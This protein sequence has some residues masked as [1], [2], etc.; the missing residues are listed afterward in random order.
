MVP[1]MYTRSNAWRVASRKRVY[2]GPIISAGKRALG[3]VAPYVGAAGAAIAASIRGKKSKGAQEYSVNT[4]QHDVVTRYRKRHMSRRRR[5]RYVG[6]VKRVQGVIAKMEPLQTYNNLYYSNGS[7]AANKGSFFG[8][9][10]GGSQVSNN[11]EL[12]QI[13]Y[14]LYNVSTL[15]DVYNR[16][17]LVKSICM[18]FMVTNT[19]SST[20]IVDVYHVKCRAPYSAASSMS[21]QFAANVADIAASPGAGAS[22]IANTD[23]GITPFDVPNFCRTWKIVSKKELVISSGQCTTLQLRNAR[24]KIIT[25]RMLN[26]YPQAI[27]G[28]S[29]GYFITW[30]GIPYNNAGTPEFQAATI[31]VGVCMSV[32]YGQPP[33]SQQQEAAQ[34]DE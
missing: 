22:T 13:M 4:T 2:G 33:G 12:Q 19:G 29:E 27:P 30:H 11:N 34:S 3:A 20:I 10:L 32:K 24:N 15:A 9:I 8:W 18:D 23:L 17:V 1:S 25:G 7:S 16:K 14:S 6:F 28:Y 26:S 31:T 21:T 5:K